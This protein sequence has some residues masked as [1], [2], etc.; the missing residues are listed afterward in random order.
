MIYNSGKRE[1]TLRDLEAWR[2]KQN[3]HYWFAW[4]PVEI[5]PYGYEKVWL[6]F[7]E[8]RYQLR[9]DGWSFWEYRIPE[10]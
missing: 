1:R 9:D 6:Q 8:C 7:V 4:Y 2:R 10:Q 3:W 5:S